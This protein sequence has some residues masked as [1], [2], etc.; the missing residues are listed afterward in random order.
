MLTLLRRTVTVVLLLVLVGAALSAGNDAR[1]ASRQESALIDA[2]HERILDRFRNLRDE[3]FGYGRVAVRATTPHSFDIETPSEAGAISNLRNAGLQV[4]A[5]VVGR[6]VLH[7]KDATTRVPGPEAV[8]PLPVVVRRALQ[9]PVVITRATPGVNGLSMPAAE[10]LM[11]DG[12]AA[13]LAFT[14]VESTQ[15]ARDGWS[16]IAR[17]VRAEDSACF[18]C[19]TEKSAVNPSRP[20]AL[21]GAVLY[22]FRPVTN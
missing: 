6:S 9:G 2:L 3:R 14:E 10:A 17:P 8:I 22:G 15:F 21:L 13:M 1:R 5:F 4:I 11:D 20:E 7:Q 16:F 18:A 12:R 19:H